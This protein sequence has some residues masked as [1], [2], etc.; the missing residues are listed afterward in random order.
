MWWDE[1]VYTHIAVT[2]LRPDNVWL[3][4]EVHTHIAA[5]NLRPGILWWDEEVPTHIA[6]TNHEARH[7]VVGRGGPHSHCC[8]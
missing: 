5:T 1:E 2:N 4:E 7:C 6:A 3:D 8:Y